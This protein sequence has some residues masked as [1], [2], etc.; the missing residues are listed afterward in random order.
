[1]SAPAKARLSSVANSIRLLRLQDEV[2]ALLAN[3]GEV[4]SKRF[5]ETR[6]TIHCR[7]PQRALSRLLEHGTTVRPHGG[8]GQPVANGDGLSNGRQGLGSPRANGAA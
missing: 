5:D 7:I 3:Y 4:L 2:L 8:N 1:M 6:V